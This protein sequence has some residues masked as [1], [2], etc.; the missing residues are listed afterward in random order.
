MLAFHKRI[1]A[2]GGLALRF[3]ASAC[4]TVSAAALICTSATPS[5]AAE[6]QFGTRSI[7][8]CSTVNNKPSIAQAVALVRCHQE[9]KST[10]DIVLLEDLQIQMGGSQPYNYHA[11]S[12]LTGIDTTSQV[13]PIRGSFTFYDCSAISVIPVIN[14]DNRGKNCFY[15]KKPTATGFCWK[16]TFGDWNC[17]LGDFDHIDVVSNQPPPHG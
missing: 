4:A 16:T 17:S 7:Q 3:L 13:Y 11:H 15:S 8:T 6:A 5:F 10:R 2:S 9:N 12:Y 14:S 1:F